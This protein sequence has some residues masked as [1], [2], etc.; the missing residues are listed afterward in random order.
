M[1]AMLVSVSCSYQFLKPAP[2]A[3]KKAATAPSEIAI[4]RILSIAPPFSDRVAAGIGTVA[5][6]L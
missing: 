3:I 5:S 1:G 4:L 6:V 2:A